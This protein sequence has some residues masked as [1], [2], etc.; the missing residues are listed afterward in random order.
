MRG[1]AIRP[2]PRRWPRHQRRGGR[3][4]TGHGPGHDRRAPD[5]LPLPGRSPSAAPDTRREPGRALIARFGQ[6]RLAARTRCQPSSSGHSRTLRRAASRMSCASMPVRDSAMPNAGHSQTNSSGPAGGSGQVHH[7]ETNE[8]GPPP[9]ANGYR[10]GPAGSE[11]WSGL[12]PPGDCRRPCR[13]RRTAGRSGRSGGT[14]P[15]HAARR[16]GAPRVAGARPDPRGQEDLDPGGEGG[17]PGDRDG[18]L[19]GPPEQQ[20]IDRHDAGKF[21]LRRFP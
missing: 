15:D 19:L 5:R 9:P 7:R 18:D 1:P 8:C 2:A 20:G 4:R 12:P 17:Q 16:A 13:R 3:A 11:S 10:T 21:R 6:R 14:R